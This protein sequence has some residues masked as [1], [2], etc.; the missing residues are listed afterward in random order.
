MKSG[1]HTEHALT[2][3]RRALEAALALMDVA[4][5][6]HVEPTTSPV[7]FY[8]SHTS[9]MGHRRFLRLAREGAFPSHRVGRTVFAR[10]EVVDAWIAAQPNGKKRSEP[11]TRDID[12]LLA[13]AGVRPGPR[14]ERRG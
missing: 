14:Q 6:G 2:I 11:P 1:M 3:A 12:A 5:G 10:R 8:T 13:R 4:E 7:S 9:P